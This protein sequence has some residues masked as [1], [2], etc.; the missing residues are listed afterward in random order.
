MSKIKQLVN[1][2]NLVK[3]R[4]TIQ[5]LTFILFVYGGYF[6]IDFGSRLPIFAC[7]YNGEAV[8]TCYLIPLQHQL[9][10]PTEIY[11]QP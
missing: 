3:V 8:G 11:S 4:F 1:N 9:S 6:A 2:M 7:P 10:R 5:L